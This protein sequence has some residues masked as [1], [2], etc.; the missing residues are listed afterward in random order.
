MAADKDESITVDWLISY[1]MQ[2]SAFVPECS[3]TVAD[4]LALGGAEEGVSLTD[5][6][7]GVVEGRGKQLTEG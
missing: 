3:A 5:Q 4:R 7:R 1:Q 2:F 6:G